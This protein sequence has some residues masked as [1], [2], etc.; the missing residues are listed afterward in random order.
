M[1]PRLSTPTFGIRP[2]T[3]AL[4]LAVIFA[5]T[6]A[7]TLL[8]GT[9][10][11]AQDS[12]LAGGQIVEEDLDDTSIEA[13]PQT[14]PPLDEEALRAT[15]E[16]AESLF[17]SVDQDASL[18]IFGRVVDLLE[19][20]AAAGQLDDS[21]RD[22]L[23]RSLA[24]RARLQF[25]FGEVELAEQG[26]ARMLELHPEADLD[27]SQASP[28]LVAQFDAL[29]RR[30]L[31]EINFVLEPVDAEV[32]IDGRKVDALAGPVAVLAGPRQIDVTL[33][34]YAPIS[35]PLAIESDASITLELTLERTSAVVR[36]L[37][38]PAGAAVSIDG[39]EHGLTEG[40][41]PEGALPQGVAATYRREE[42][43]DE[44]IIEGIELGLITLEVRK[45]GYRSERLELSISDLL[46]YPLA[47]IVLEKERGSLTFDNFPPGAEIRVDGKL[48][49]PDNPGARRPTLTLAPG[50][51]HVTVATRSSQ[52]FS[53]QL[54]LADR[55]RMQINVELRPGLAFLGVLGGDEETARNLDQV[56][57]LAL[58][59]SGKWTLINRSA[60]APAVLADAGVTAASL[61]AVEAEAAAG[62]RS[63]ID[64]R[65]V[66][67]AVDEQLP[68]LV[69]V[70]AVPSNDL[71]ATH[72]T[73]WIWPHA[74]GPAEPD[75]V[76]LPLGDPQA[77]AGLKASFNRTIR[78]KRS[79]VGALLIDTQAEPHPLVVDVTPASPAELAGLAVGDLVVGVAGVPVTHRAAFDE[80]IAAAEIGETLDLGVQSPSG[81]RT[82]KLKLGS[83]PD[84]LAARRA[85][86]LDAVAFT[87]LVLLAEKAPADAA[88]IVE[89]DQALILLRANEWTEAARKLRSI[90]APQTSHGVG[91]ATVDYLLGIALSAA[92]PSFIEG[93]R[94]HFEKAAGLPG[95]RLFHNDGAWVAPRA[96]ARL[97]M[98]GG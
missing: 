44:K 19:P 3:W 87:E 95:A 83:S 28:K 62:S 50:Q 77:L 22:L 23:T 85:D 89:L 80:R 1:A 5:T 88:W 57:R 90:R 15:F 76:R 74:P 52:M 54:Q 53:T 42:F 2:W 59:D 70:V 43:S 30:L 48:R 67:Q 84:L 49:S 14:F 94:Q 8:G 55:Q 82:L 24:Y 27:R 68:G 20:R 58:T 98:L 91:Q 35:R 93:A 46:D 92:G 18:P 31:G 26:L 64:W 13:L 71:V 60:Q 29:R 17:A 45:E 41:A 40:T 25:N 7:V 47:P 38:R 73:L 6:L 63:S 39:T 75:H 9:A 16:E 21:L 4:T 36:L 97:R 86:L 12:P 66:Q 11:W 34:G 37:T 72:A 69:Y 78:L 65:R 56:L 96:R 61:R 51:Y 32:H 79:W 10:A 33:P 81:P